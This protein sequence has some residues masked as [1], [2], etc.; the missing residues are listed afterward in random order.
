MPTI[1]D[2]ENITATNSSMQTE[3][4]IAAVAGPYLS[5]VLVE[6][7]GQSWPLNGD[8]INIDFVTLETFMLG[9]DLRPDPGVVLRNQSERS[10]GASM[11]VLFN[12]GVHRPLAITLVVFL[13]SLVMRNVTQVF[14]ITKIGH[15][16]DH[17]Q[18]VE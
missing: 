2:E 8:V 17:D 16:S 12:G 5:G 11:R 6:L 1:T 10:L 14:F 15:S 4:G 13:L 9:T 7:P 3:Q 18:L